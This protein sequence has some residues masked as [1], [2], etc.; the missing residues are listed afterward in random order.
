M[1]CK[2]KTRRLWPYWTAGAA[3]VLGL[4][5][6]TYFIVTDEAPPGKDHGIN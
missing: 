3:A 2:G 4:G 1:P 5:A 6:A